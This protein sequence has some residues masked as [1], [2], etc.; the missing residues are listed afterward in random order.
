MG[1]VCTGALFLFDNSESCAGHISQDVFM[2]LSVAM[3]T[4]DVTVALG[5]IIAVDI[6]EGNAATN[7]DEYGNVI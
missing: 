1:G 4:T 2:P 7:T 6:V 5:S 3:I